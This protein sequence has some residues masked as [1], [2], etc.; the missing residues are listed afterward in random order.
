MNVNESV[1][2]RKPK[3][4]NEAKYHRKPNTKKCVTTCE[5]TIVVE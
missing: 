5:K 4:F 3:N 2:P 1:S